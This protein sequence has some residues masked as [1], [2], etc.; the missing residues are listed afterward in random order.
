MGRIEG[1]ER[2]L[3]HH[4]KMTHRLCLAFLHGD[5]GQILPVQDNLPLCRLLQ[6]HQ[7]LREG[8][9]AAAGFANDGD[10]FRLA[11]IEIDILVRLHGFY[12]VAADHGDDRA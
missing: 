3:E 10:G 5:I 11:R 7:D 4:L 6:P 12:R 2:V 9:F 8:G 1:V